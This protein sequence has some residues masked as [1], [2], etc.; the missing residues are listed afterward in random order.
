MHREQVIWRGQ[1]AEPSRSFKS[2]LEKHDNALK[3][4]AFQLAGLGPS[5]PF[6]L[7]LAGI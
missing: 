7:T 6:V 1:H 2:K 4:T 5:T 3:P